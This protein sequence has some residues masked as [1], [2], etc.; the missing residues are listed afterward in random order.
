MIKYYKNRDLS[1]KLGINLARWKRWSR[2]FLPP[3]P[4]GG[5]Q[6]GYARQYSLDKAF[7]V[8]LGGYLVGYMKFAV[9][10]AKQILKDLNNW[11]ADNGF[12][13]I[14]IKNLKNSD[15]NNIISRYIIYIY[16][17]NEDKNQLDFYYKIRRIIS[18]SKADY[19]GREARKEIYMETVIKQPDKETSDQNAIKT[20]M[21]NIT[22]VYAKFLEGFKKTTALF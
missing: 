10:D 16:E 1:S 13:I 2:E 22:G 3:D 11:L 12:Y 14:D 20:K 19:K 15:G 7:E 5:M 8:F 6:S 17:N 4:L 18:S 9:P 21:L